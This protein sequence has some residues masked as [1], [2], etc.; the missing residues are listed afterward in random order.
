[1]AVYCLLDSPVCH[2][3]VAGC[4]AVGGSACQRGS[5]D[6][7]GD[8]IEGCDPVNQT[9]VEIDCPARCSRHGPEY[10]GTCLETTAQEIGLE[11][12]EGPLHTCFCR[13]MAP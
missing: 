6:C 12:A 5:F 10:Y 2:Q 3:L 7:V 9:P 1:M 11:E 8:R 4:H 13:M